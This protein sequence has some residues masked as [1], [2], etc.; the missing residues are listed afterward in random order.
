MGCATVLKVGAVRFVRAYQANFCFAG[1]PK[2]CKDPPKCGG[3]LTKCWGLYN[4]IGLAVDREG[5]VNRRGWGVI[6]PNFDH[7][8]QETAATEVVTLLSGINE[9]FSSNSWN[10]VLQ[11]YI[12]LHLLTVVKRLVLCKSINK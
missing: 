2:V 6:W 9:L 3:V 10:F 5:Y 11:F 8:D 12:L 4:K 1:P 7:F